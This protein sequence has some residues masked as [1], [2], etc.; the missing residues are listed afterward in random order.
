MKLAMTVTV[1]IMESQRWVCRIHEFQFTGTSYQ[2][3]SCVT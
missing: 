3:I 1:K 2:R